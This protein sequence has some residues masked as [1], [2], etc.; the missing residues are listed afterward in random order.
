MSNPLAHDSNA[1][2]AADG[3]VQTAT[4]QFFSLRTHLGRFVW[5]VILLTVF[6]SKALIALA[7]HVANS[8]LHSYILLVPVISVYLIYNR[9]DRL[10]RSYSSSPGLAVIPLLGGLAAL[11]F[12]VTGPSLS[13]NDHLS[14]IALAYFCLLTAGAFFFLGRSWM[15][16]VAF[17]FAFLI[18]IVPMP[19]S[20]ANVLER[21]SQLASTEAANLFFDG[22][23]TPVMRDGTIFQ[24][25]NIAIQVGQEC[26]GIR[27]SVVLFLTSLVGANL[28][29]KN[30]WRQALFIGF[31]IPLGILRNGF[32]VWFIGTLCIYFGPHM[33]HSVFHRRGG[34]VFFILSLIPLFLLLW[35]LRRGE[36]RTDGSRKSEA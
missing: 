15:K 32:R 22:T 33:I 28:F 21:A 14:L 27:S 10:T 36:E 20:M 25:P 11:V 19:D 12:A 8:D 35:W 2:A 26:S 30:R 5:F 4:S 16:A 7:I 1:P 6:F 23:G 18:F 24:L 17:P 34:P 13:H 9:R 3:T 31:V 29:L